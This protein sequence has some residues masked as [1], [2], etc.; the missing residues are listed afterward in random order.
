LT[1][2]VQLESGFALGKLLAAF[3][4]DHDFEQMTPAF[5]LLGPR[6]SFLLYHHF[7]HEATLC[8]SLTSLAVSI[9]QISGVYQF[10]SD[11]ISIKF[12]TAACVPYQP[13][14]S[15]FTLCARL[16]RS[17]DAPAAALIL[18]QQE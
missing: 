13:L 12:A 11:Q 14:L 2:L 5:Q 8:C 17:F 3:L 10:D 16:R 18:E 4:G 6:V 9:A 15:W 7:T 1:A